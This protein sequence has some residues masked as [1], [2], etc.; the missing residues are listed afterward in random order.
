M[1]TEVEGREDRRE[2]KTGNESKNA[3]QDE[4]GTAEA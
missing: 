4:E 1:R 3:Q 2:E